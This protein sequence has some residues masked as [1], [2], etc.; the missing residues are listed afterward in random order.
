MKMMWEFV[1]QIL[2]K[3]FIASDFYVTVELAIVEI[4]ESS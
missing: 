2:V 3:G 4:G 1:K